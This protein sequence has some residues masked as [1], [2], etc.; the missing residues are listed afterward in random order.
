MASLVSTI[1]L[2]ISPCL[3]VSAIGASSPSWE[4]PAPVWTR[5]DSSSPSPTIPYAPPTQASSSSA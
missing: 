5:A 2:T 4:P 3:L 1:Q